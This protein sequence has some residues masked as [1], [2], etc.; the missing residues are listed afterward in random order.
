MVA[1]AQRLQRKGVRV[2]EFPQTVANLTA[3]TKLQR[4]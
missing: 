3:Y 4:H 2:E 1:V